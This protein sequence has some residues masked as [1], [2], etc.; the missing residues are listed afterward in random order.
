LGG[1]RG[2]EVFDQGFVVLRI[3]E[4]QIILFVRPEMNN[5]SAV[6]MGWLL[7]H[8]WLYATQ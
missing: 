2:L 7:A 3:Q 5:C 1:K 6:L 4:F 8:G